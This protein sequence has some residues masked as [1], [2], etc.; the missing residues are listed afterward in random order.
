MG[1]LNWLIVQA[2]LEDVLKY[3]EKILIHLYDLIYLVM[4]F[5]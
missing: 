4:K 1:L 3:Q 2:K 5:W